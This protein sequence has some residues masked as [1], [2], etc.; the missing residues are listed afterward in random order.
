MPQ[1]NLRMPDTL[2]RQL[3]VRTDAARGGLSEAIRETLE[4]YFY[5]IDTSRAE[6]ADNF[7]Q[8]EVSLLVDICNG[9][10]F[11]PLF[12]GAV[13]ANVEDAEGDYF[14]KWSVNRDA[15]ILKLRLLTPVQEL[16]LVDAIERFWN[17]VSKSRT[18]EQPNPGEALR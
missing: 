1:I 17:A 18:L 15:L 6:I 4:R 2:I 7:T 10:W 3:D 16:A 11:E 9:T 14:D 5:L 12:T 13:R 8:G